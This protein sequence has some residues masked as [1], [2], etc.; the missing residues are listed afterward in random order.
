MEQKPLSQRSRR[1]ILKQTLAVSAISVTGLATVTM[2]SI[3]FTASLSK[4]ERDGMTPKSVI[5]HLK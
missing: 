2:P 5:E 1:T 4:E 3:S